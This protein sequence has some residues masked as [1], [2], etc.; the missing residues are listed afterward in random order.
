MLVASFE[1]EARAETDRGF[2][3]LIIEDDP[4]VRSQLQ[5][6]LQTEYRL[7][8]IEHDD[9]IL[10]A[11]RKQPFH[12]VLLDVSLLEAKGLNALHAIRGNPPSADVPIIL[13]APP[14]DYTV[15]VRGLQLGASDYITPPLDDEVVRGRISTQLALK[16]AENERE[17]TI[18]QL[19]FTQE[20]QENFA[21][22][23]SHDL[24]G[25]LTN[26][27]MAQFMLRDMLRDNSEAHSILD[28]MDVT[29]N[30][31]IDM[32]RMFLDAVDSQR[33]EPQPAALHVHNLI[34]EVAEQY[35]L[36]ADRKQIR[37]R[38]GNGDYRA[39]A[40][41]KLLRQVLGNLIS[42]AIKFSPPGS[43]VRIW[44]EAQDNAIRIHVSDQGPGILP[45]ERGKLFT[46]F[47]KLS[48]RPTGGETS[49]GLGLWIVKQLTELQGGRV[50]VDQTDG[51]GS[52]FWVELPG[53]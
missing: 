53:A 33:L 23:V 35:H 36:A 16:H 31:M 25:P 4:G 22:I 18:S 2:R 11:L 48:A 42:N 12:L 6:F 45:E 39:L 29:L 51:E 3:L 9:N 26:I 32:I 10:A 44:A 40:D 47:G 50:G 5:A 24:K 41:R 38:L 13:I 21:R 8:F 43:E 17:Q 30:G 7:T 28:S 52:V 14:S 19:K 34:V 27:R 1:P 15:A 46:M 37:L 20:M 49:T